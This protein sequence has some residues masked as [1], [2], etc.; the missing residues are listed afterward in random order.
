MLDHFKG[1]SVFVTGGSGFIGG[2]LVEILHRD[3]G[4]KVKA[5]INN[6][7][8]GL[9]MARYDIEF[10]FDDMTD[11]EAM[12][13][14][15]KG[16]D[17]VFHCAFGSAGSP[18]EQR[19]ITVDGT[20]AVGA[21][22]V[23]G[24]V[25]RLVNLSTAAVYGETPDGIV[26]E[27]YPHK[28]D[29][30]H[31]GEIKLEA[32]NVLQELGQNSDLPFTTLQLVGVYGP[33][34]NYFTITPLKQLATSRLVL[35]N[36][37]SGIANATYVDDVIQAM[38]L[39]AIKPKAIGETF[40]IKGAGTVTRRMFAEAY[41][42]MLGAHDALISMTPDEIKRAARNERR[43]QARRTIPSALNALRLDQSFRKAFA[44]SPANNIPKRLP[45]SI[46]AK[47]KG[48][49]VPSQNKAREEST[50]PE[51]PIIYPLDMMIPRLAAKTDFSIEKARYLLGYEPH[52]DLEKGMALTKVW[53]E[54]ARLI[55]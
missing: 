50:S 19:R 16:C 51:K 21:A 6:P 24:G 15:I 33:W 47:L 34:G 55:P 46:K 8:N 39:A 41:A 53:A 2:R 18:E 38:M 17:Y 10:V 37:G 48:S 28:S 30:W 22:A 32:E 43:K 1:K 3:A 14:L 44:N 11:L 7:A 4:A 13:R 5:L 35:V 54:W 27:S 40:L 23:S 52:Y 9:R 31:Y 49:G 42:S 26:D 36:D 29:G 20:R 45:E 25:S 12:E